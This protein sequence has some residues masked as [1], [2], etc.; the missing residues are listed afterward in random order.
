MVAVIRRRCEWNLR[1]SADRQGDAQM[2]T[3]LYVV[4]GQVLKFPT[5]QAE[6]VAHC[7]IGMPSRTYC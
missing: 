1:C 3:I 7:Y 5:K 4:G 2:S 6:R